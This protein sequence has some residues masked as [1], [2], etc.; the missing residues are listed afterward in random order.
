MD[1]KFAEYL[2]A[3]GRSASTID[4]YGKCLDDFGRWFKAQNGCALT[5]LDVTTTDARQYRAWMLL[6]AHLRPATIN[7]RLAALRA[8]AVCYG[9]EIGRIRGLAEAKAA[10]RWLDKTDQGRLMREIEREINASR[11]IAG[12]RQAVRNRAVIV[13]LANSGLR[14]GE[15]CEL[16]PADLEIG[17]RSGKV[18]V[19]Q[20]KGDKRREVPL[21]ADA[22][23]ALRAWIAARP[24]D[25]EKLFVNQRSGPLNQGGVRALLARYAQ[26]A[27]LKVAPHQMR[28]T[29]AKNLANAGV[30]I[31]HIQM[32]M[33]HDDIRSTMRYTLPD[34][35]DL[36]RDVA[37]LEA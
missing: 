8:Y 26:R 32:L 12:Q 35:R 31:D 5:P 6:S 13:L 30:G 17:E 37:K 21:N 3:L 22:R 9:L 4:D 33:G 11:T 10:P 2:A 20:G 16:E 25:G 18:V 29:F 1:E 23:Q 27:G 7:Q 34:E 14:I 28:H 15:L 19:R 24:D 36:A